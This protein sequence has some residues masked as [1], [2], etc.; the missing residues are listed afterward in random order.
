MARTITRPRERFIDGVKEGSSIWI[1]LLR[2]GNDRMHRFNRLVLEEAERSQEEGAELFGQFLSA[3]TQL[4]QFTNSLVITLQERGR[5]RANLTRRLVNDLGEVAWD[6]RRLLS[7]ATDAG[8]KTVTATAS[9]G[10]EAASR[11]AAEVAER[12][13]DVSDSTEGLSRRLERANARAIGNGSPATPAKR[14]RRKSAGRTRKKSSSAN[15]S[16]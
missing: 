4:G 2:E 9:A 5:R 10:R 3:P 13:E 1:D 7:R 12:A 14:P 8:R 15:G 6:T 16:R 11:V